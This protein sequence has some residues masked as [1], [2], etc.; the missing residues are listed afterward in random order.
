MGT[1]RGKDVEG[2]DDVQ[3]KKEKEAVKN[4]QGENGGG[5][6]VSGPFSL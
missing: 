5:G 2:E 1:Q 6:G 3:N 4:K